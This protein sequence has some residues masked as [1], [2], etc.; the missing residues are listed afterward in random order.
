MSLELLLLAGV[1]V[2]VGVGIVRMLITSLD[3]AHSD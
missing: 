3:H 1:F 2:L